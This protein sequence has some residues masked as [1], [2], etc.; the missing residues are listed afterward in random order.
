MA[1]INSAARLDR[2]WLSRGMS[3]PESLRA[4]RTPLP[5]AEGQGDHMDVAKLTARV[6]RRLDVPNF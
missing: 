1:A 6:K 4:Q 5:R 3:D 2:D